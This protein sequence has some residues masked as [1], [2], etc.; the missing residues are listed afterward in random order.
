ML[1]CSFHVAFARKVQVKIPEKVLF[2]MSL[3][4]YKYGLCNY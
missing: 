2:H 3:F 1:F 4:A